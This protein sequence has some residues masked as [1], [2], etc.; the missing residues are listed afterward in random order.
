MPTRSVPLSAAFLLIAMEL[1]GVLAATAQALEPRPNVVVIVTNDQGFGDMGRA[2]ELD[3]HE[4]LADPGSCQHPLETALQAAGLGGFTPNLDQLAREGVRFGD[5]HVT[6]T[7]ATTRA[8]LMTGRLNQRTGVVSSTTDR[9]I[10]SPGETTLAEIFRQAGYRTGIFGIW[11]LG[12]NTPARARDRGFDEALTTNGGNL[13]T[14][15][16]YWNN[17]CFG[18]TYFD[19]DGNGI[20]FGLNNDPPQP[21]DPYCTEIFFGEARRFITDHV[22]QTPD[23]PFFAYIVP[24][25]AR[26]LQTA[27]PRRFVPPNDPDPSI[28]YESLGV[29]PVLADFYGAI[30]GI[31][32]HLGEL[33][34]LLQSMDLE[35]NTI[36][37]VLADNG[38]QLTIADP[39]EGFAFLLNNYGINPFLPGYRDFINPAGLRSRK[40]S[41]HD[42]G[43]RVFLFMRWP[44]GG[45][46]S[47]NVQQIDA[48]TH[49]S[50]LFPTLLDLAGIEIDAELKESLDGISMASLL[51]GAPDDAFDQR[52]VFLQQD[53]GIEDPVTGAFTPRPLFNFMVSTPEWRL[54]RP[55]GAASQLYAVS[56]RAQATDVAAA[57]PGVVADLEGRWSDYYA[58][59]VGLYDDAEDRGR[60][61]IGDPSAPTQALANNSWIRTEEQS[62]GFRNAIQDGISAFE[63]EVPS[64]GFWALDVTRSG[65]Y[66]IKLR[67]WPGSD[68]APPAIADQPID[69]RGG[70][71]A[72]L[73]I[74]PEYFDLDT[75]SLSG[76]GP[77]FVDLSNPIG[78]GESESEFLVILEKGP[79]FLGGELTGV[80]EFAVGCDV[81][82]D[83]AACPAVLRSPYFAVVSP[84][85]PAV[86]GLSP[87][88]LALLAVVLAGAGFVFRPR[89]R[90]TTGASYT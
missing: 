18:D 36:V 39:L 51:A 25:A 57:N 14:T 8:A 45:I 16:D 78:A 73:V 88:A 48:L 79:V 63:N 54:V 22:S 70:G 30:H 26:D 85:P 7:C 53:V 84:V 32:E 31:D 82:V 27:P 29:D 6:P 69:P 46:T 61:V 23:E 71:S 67:R 83:P 86:P 4:P 80:S 68:L 47:E 41:V 76:S 52:T 87:G 62:R 64:R 49:V 20:S 72:R 58:S 81:T 66:S 77:N 17:D 9:R 44:D 3:C 28:A 50:D 75:V 2:G 1:S 37:V 21:G 38:S 74:S 65:E 11:N 90:S 35:D 55:D 19:E 56:D 89:A 15:S 13:R 34:G 59:W 60:I 43:H 40:G 10:L 24:T 12:D 33:R 5:F 42:G